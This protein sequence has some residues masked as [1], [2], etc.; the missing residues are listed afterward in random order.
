MQ[1][2]TSL[3]KTRGSR[4]STGT[5]Q[6]AWGSNKRAETAGQLGSRLPSAAGRTRGRYL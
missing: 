1:K 4:E 2:N 5:I 6:S 3:T